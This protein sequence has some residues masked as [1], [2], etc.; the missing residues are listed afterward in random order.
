MQN[1]ECKIL[2]KSAISLLKES[3]DEVPRHEATEFS[4]KHKECRRQKFCAVE[5]EGY[6]NDIANKRY[7]REECHPRTIFIDLCLLLGEGFWLH[8][9]L[10]NPLPLADA[11]YAIRGES[12]K[13]VAGCGYGYNEPRRASGNKHSH[14]QYICAEWHDGRRQK[15]ADKEP[16]VS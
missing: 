12:A 8:A 9:E 6:G 14:Q 11:T 13:E 4:D 2:Q 10:F 5:A 1:A 3:V 7:P 16:E 15:R